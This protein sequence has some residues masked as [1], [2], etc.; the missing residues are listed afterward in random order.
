MAQ[1]TAPKLTIESAVDLFILDARARRFTA[2]T[3]RFYRGRLGLFQRWLA[4]AGVLFLADIESSHI[5]RYFVSLQEAGRSSAYV[6]SFGRAIRA[7][8]NYCVR[9]EVIAISPF[10][11][12]KMPV[13]EK[14]VKGA[15]SGEEVRK[16]L[17]A[18]NSERDRAIVLLLLDAGLRASELLALKVG[19]IDL[20]TGAVTIQMGK[21]QKGRYSWLGLKTRRQVGRYLLK[22]RHGDASA[23]AP[24]FMTKPTAGRGRGKRLGYK[25]LQ[26]MLLKTAER[27]KVEGATAHALRRTFA[28]NC[29]R[30]GMDIHTLAKLMGHAD[31]KVLEYYLPFIQS[32]LEQAHEKHGPVDHMLE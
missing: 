9:D 28:I 23:G 27:A 7:W 25:G 18:C 29:L 13:L 20:D 19:D 8:L 10:N 31:T 2:S 15:L 1:G 6:H 32:D 16:L 21:G 11:R 26:Q 22:E 30:N 12:V 5:K 3:L 14:K 17:R 24:L 4:D